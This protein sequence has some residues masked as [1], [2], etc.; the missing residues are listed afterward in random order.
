MTPQVSQVRFLIYLHL[1]CH[2]CHYRHRCHKVNR[3][4]SKQSDRCYSE[5]RELFALASISSH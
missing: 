3:R 1:K 2:K 4:N 5:R